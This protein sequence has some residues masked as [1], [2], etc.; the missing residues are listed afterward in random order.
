MSAPYRRPAAPSPEAGFDYGPFPVPRLLLA[1]AAPLVLVGALFVVMGLDH[2]E[3]RCED[4]TCVYQRTTLVRS[5]SR[6]FPLSQLHGAQATE[7]RSKNGVRGQVRLDV[8]GQPFLLS[9]TS[10]GEARYVAR[11]IKQH[12]ANADS[13]WMVR[14]DNERWPAAAGA[15]A[16]LL[17]LAALLWAAKGSGTLR[18]EVSGEGLRWRR[19]LL[20]IRLASG[21]TPLPRDVNDVV[22]EWSTRRT[23]FQHRHEPPKTFGR[24]AVVTQRG[25]KVP[26]LGAYAGHAVHL[27]AAAELRDALE[28]PPRTP[29]RE[30]EYERSAAAARP[31]ET[32]STFAGVG[33]RFAAV[34]LGLCVG[35]IS[36]IALFGMGKLLL[37][38]GSIDDPVGTLDL[39]LGAGGGA[40]G[41]V[42][43]ALRLTTRRRAED[44]HAP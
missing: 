38:V 2:G 37:R 26:V 17:A 39:L 15:V 4:T 18:V 5:R 32:P 30:A 19:R 8:N 21:E 10:V 12:V 16:L 9:S 35:A 6:A 41:G 13:R 43:L 33:G 3:L 20:G 23:F 28:L 31:A 14:Q 7:I 1:L 29:E 36:G 42:W 40:A 44:Q 11:S 22:I 25:T 24:L 27:R 34:W